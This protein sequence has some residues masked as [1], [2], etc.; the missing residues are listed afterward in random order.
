MNET[1]IKDAR[2]GNYKRII[3]LIDECADL[4][5]Q[6][7][8]DEHNNLLNIVLY[9]YRSHTY[10]D[11]RDELLQCVIKLVEAGV[12]VNHL[13]KDKQTPVSIAARK[14]LSKIVIYLIDHGVDIEYIDDEHNNLLHLVLDSYRSYHPGTKDELLQ[15]VIKL[16]EAGVDVNHLNKD[17][18][19]PVSIAARKELSKIVIYLIFHGVD[20]EYIDDEHNNLLHLVLDSY[21]SYHPG[22]KDELL[23][24]VIQLVEAGVDVNHLN[25]DQQTPISVAARKGL[26][27]IVLYLIDHCVDI[28]Y[29]DRE[30]NNFLHLVLSSAEK[31]GGRERDELLQCV[32]KLVQAGV[33]VNHLNEEQQT[34]IDV[35]ARHG[36]YNIFIYLIDYCVGIQ[37]TGREQNNAL[38]LVLYSARTYDEIEEDGLLQCVIKLV[39]AG[40]DVNHMNRYELTPIHIAVL[41]GLYNNVLYLID[42]CVDIQYTNRKQNNFLHLVLS[43]AEE[44][45]GRERDELL[46][47]VIKLVK[48]GVDVNHLN[49]EQQTPIDVAARHG[50]YN[51]FIYLIDYCVGIQYTDRVQ[52]N[53]LHLVLYSARTYDEIEEDGLLQYVIKLVKAGV[54]VNH[55]NEEQQTPIDVAA[56]HGLYNIFIYLIDYCVGIQYT[57]RVQN[58]VLHLVLYSARTYDEIE[59]DG[60]LQ[61]VIKLVKAG[62]DVNHLNRYE[63]TPLHIAVGCRLYNIVLYLIDHCVD[64]QYTD[65][66]QNNFLHLVLYSAGRYGGREKDEV[67]QC[68]IKLVKAGVDVNHLNQDQQTPI[69]VAAREGLYN[70]VLYLID[71]CVG[72]QYT[73]REQNNFLHLVLYSAGRYGEIESDELLQ[74]VIKLV[75]A[76]VDVNHLNRY[77]QTPIHIAVW[78]GFYNIVLYLIDHCVGI[79]YTDREQ[80]NVLHLVL[81]CAGRYGGREKDEVLQCVIKLVKAGVDVNHLNEEQQTPI[82]VAAR[83]GLYNIV[84]YLIDHCVGIQYTDREQNNFLHLVLSSAEEYGGRERDDGLLQCVIKLVQ[85]GVDVNHM[86][87]DQ[88]TPIHIAARKG[89]YNNVLYLID[90]CVDIQYTDREQNNFLHLVLYSAGRY[91]GREK[92]EV[93]Q[94]VIKLVKAGVDVNHLNEEQ[95]TPIFIAATNGWYNVVMYLLGHGA[96]VHYIDE[97]DQNILHHVLISI[98]DIRVDQYSDE[99]EVDPILYNMHRI[100]GEDV[101]EYTDDCIKVVKT[102]INMGVDVNKPDKDGN[103]PLFIIT[104]TPF[105]ENPLKHILF[106]LQYNLI[107]AFYNAGCNVNHQNKKGQTP[108]MYCTRGQAVIR[109]LK[110]MIQHSDVNL[111][112]NNGDTACSYCVQYHV[113]NSTNIFKLYSRD[114]LISP[115]NGVKLFHQIL[116]CKRLGLFNYYMR[117]QMIVNGVTTEGENMLHLL[118]RV[119]YDYSLDKFNWLFNKKLDI[120]HPCSK[121]NTP[122]MIAALLLNSKYLELFTRHPRLDINAQNKQGCTALHLCII[123]FTMVKDDLNNRQKNDVV[124]DYCRQIYPIYME[125]VDIL[126]AVCI[127]VN[128]QDGRG[129]TALMMATMKNDRFLIRKLLNAGA[130]VNYSGKSALHH[131]D[132]Y[133]SVFD[134]SFKLL[135]SA[136]DNMLLNL[137]CINGTTLIQATLCFPRCWDPLTAVSFIKYLV[138]EN[139]CLQSLVTSSVESSYNQIDMRELSSQERGKLR[140]LLYLSGAPENQIV[141]TLNF[142]KEDTNIERDDMRRLLCLRGSSEEEIVQQLNFQEEDKDDRDATFHSRHRVIFTKYCCNISL[143]SQCR[144]IIRQKLG[145]G[146][147]EKVMDLELPRELNDFLLLKDV[148][149]PKDYNIDNID[150]GCNDFDD[151]DGYGGYDRAKDRDDDYSRY[152]YQYFTLPTD[153][154]LRQMCIQAR[155]YPNGRYWYEI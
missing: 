27:N 119:N 89:L 136:G 14:G 38:H 138:G 26:Y 7:I 115:N 150:D 137:P 43:S 55:L 155:K 32:I 110:L 99:E 127:N 113:L 133:E 29:T 65:R 76:G 139:C 30:Q 126:L 2:S 141:A 82:S 18:Q 72:I 142:E 85:A 147:K 123:G 151:D 48:A 61:Y 35:A 19:T 12:D 60:L 117:L 130:L 17:K 28:Q 108:L 36:L 50:L 31:Y 10:Q 51:I 83:K 90:H 73:D 124:E 46:Q 86:N 116:T 100:N 125:C 79:Q 49:E 149:H 120:N 103:T 63:Q 129:R 64:I 24:Y 71:H 68:V 118:A 21:R 81:Y 62:V 97:Y 140:K 6:Y 57:D 66:E 44:Y 101:D 74:C 91:G 135:V 131:L 132:I 33:D 16:V 87:E 105:P 128:T 59:E 121:T 153:H 20:I 148:L 5:L 8:D 106:R 39:Q 23:Q 122:I 144:R 84:L 92:D 78:R 41:R 54:D 104:P 93:L 53:V 42:H 134:L 37:Y 96:H 80:N 114:V 77:E 3:H 69:S 4:P 75:Q 111:T 15:Y 95:Q 47:C 88:Q 11:D 98:Y 152:N 13:N 9:S 146:I 40:V 145:L 34:P 143:K 1:I 102:L 107:T 56:I 52:N 58:N 67:L 70:I 25:Q 112:D 109:I 154:V 94:C 22:T 45:G